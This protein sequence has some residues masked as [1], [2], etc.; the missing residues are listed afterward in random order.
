MR[1][2]AVVDILALIPASMQAHMEELKTAAHGRLKRFV[3]IEEMVHDSADNGYVVALIPATGFS[4]EE[5]W[6]IWG[7]LNDMDPRPCIL[8]YALRSDFEM[9]SSVLDAGAFDL[10]V[11]PF[12][13]EKLRRAILS[14]S[15]EFAR[16]NEKRKE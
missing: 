6:T 4:V 9:W 10:I 7:F 11:A 13:P 15:D 1:N 3:S 12:T 5:W 2:G 16:R 8:V 14:A